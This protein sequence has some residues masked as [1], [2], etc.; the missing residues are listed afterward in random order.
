MFPAVDGEVIILAVNTVEHDLSVDKSID[1]PATNGIMN[2]SK[3]WNAR[4]FPV[5]LLHEQ[6]ILRYKLVINLLKL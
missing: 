5:N 6:L 2:F 3:N 4:I 1:L